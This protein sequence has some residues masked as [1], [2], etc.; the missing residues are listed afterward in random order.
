MVGG[1]A[2]GAKAEGS[3]VMGGEE[4]GGGGLKE[5]SEGGGMLIEGAEE[6][7]EMGGVLWEMKGE[8][9]GDF[10]RQFSDRN[11]SLWACV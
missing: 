11:M 7:K 2:V 3:V 4:G 5:C 10:P 8:E 9:R 1:V 6:R